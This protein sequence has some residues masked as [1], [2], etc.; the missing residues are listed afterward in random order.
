MKQMV[1][2]VNVNTVK[3]WIKKTLSKVGYVYWENTLFLATV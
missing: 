2:R 1:L 3:D